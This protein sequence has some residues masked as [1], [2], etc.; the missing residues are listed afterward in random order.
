MKKKIMISTLILCLA[1]SLFTGCGS[2]K[3]SEK[4]FSDSH[5][6]ASAEV[7][8][9]IGSGDFYAEET[10]A[11]ADYA[12]GAPAEAYEEYDMEYAETPMADDNGGVYR[13]PSSG[14][15]SAPDTQKA[16]AKKD[17]LVFRCT[18]KVDT[19]DFDTSV[20]QLKLKINEYHGF[21][22]NEYQSDGSDYFGPY[23]LEESKKDYTYSAT[24]RIPSE[25][26]ESFVS[27]TDGLGYIRSKSSSVDNVSTQYGTLKNELEIYEAEYDRYLEQYENTKDDNVALRIQSELRNLAITISDIKTRMSSIESDVAYSYVTISIHKVTPEQIEEVVEVEEKEDTFK[28]RV[29]DAAKSSWKAFLGFLEGVLIFFIQT[30]W[31]LLIMGIIALIIFLCIRRSIRKHAKKVEAQKKETEARELS[32]AKELANAASEAEKKFAKPENKQADKPD[33][34]PEEKKDE[35]PNK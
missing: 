17:M 5:N 19:T 12:A 27:S 3:S 18:I 13:D 11:A 4:R 23:V 28:T 29:S 25:Y 35:K 24:I 16:D 22:E 34:K 26:Y 6:A 10:M 1:L 15:A 8:S 2:S 20:Q 31:G 9:E 32:R 14:N 7:L 30:W 33:T 21:L